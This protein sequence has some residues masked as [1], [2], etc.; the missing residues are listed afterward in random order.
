MPSHLTP[1]HTAAL[2]QLYALMRDGSVAMKVRLNSAV[3]AS[4]VEPLVQPGMAPPPA[5]A[6]LRNIME[7]RYEGKQYRAEWRRMAGAALT[8]WE[9]RAALAAIK[10][11]VADTSEEQAQWRRILNGLLRR[12]LWAH[13]RWPQDKGLLLSADVS[14]LIPCSSELAL[15]ALLLPADPMKRRGRKTALDEPDKAVIASEEERHDVLRQIAALLHQ[16]L[17]AAA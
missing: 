14:V 16:R 1:L 9:R 12:H 6:F 11:K 15:A 13:G 7:Y 10:F 17:A 5:V 3:S 4:R 2:D 8:Y